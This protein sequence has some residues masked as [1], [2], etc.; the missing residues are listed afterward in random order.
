MIL[1]YLINIVT[2]PVLPNLQLQ[3]VPTGTDDGEIH[4]TEGDNQYNIWFAKDMRGMPPCENSF[5]LGELLRGFFDYYA[6]KFAWGQ[7]VISIRTRG[8]LL[9]KQEKGWVAAK[10][11]PGNAADG[12]ETWEV[13]D[14]YVWDPCLNSCALL[15]V[16]V[17]RYLFALE[18]PFETA[19]NVGRTCNGP[20][21]LGTSRND[22]TVID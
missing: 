4:Y 2:P 17:G 3:P 16:V 7:A 8:G 1:H 18:D 22:K 13:K 14:R 20:G 12:S 6:Y 15:T 21:M 9:T 5:S 10:S 11:R 19:H